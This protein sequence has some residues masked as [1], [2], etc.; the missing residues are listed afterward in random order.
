MKTKRRQPISSA[1]IFKLMIFLAYLVSALFFVKDILGGDI[2]GACIIGAVLGVFT[3]AL[4]VMRLLKVKPDI[5]RL[6]VA[7]S[8]IVIVFIVSLTTGSYY[9]DD[10]SLYLAVIALNGL[11]F[12]KKYSYVQMAM[13]DIFLV[14]Q[15]VVYPHKA[16]P[17]GQFIMCMATFNLAAI[18]ICLL[19]SRGSAFIENN[20][21]R[22]AAAEETLKELET[23]GLELE[24]NFAASAG[25]MDS[26][27]A[28]NHT[29]RESADTLQRNSSGISDGA[30]SVSVSCDNVRSRMQ[31]TTENVHALDRGVKRFESVLNENRSNMA[32]MNSQMS[33]VRN[34]I[35]ETDRVFHLL[36]EQMRKI[37]SVTGEIN[38][39]ASNTGLLAVNASIEAARAGE[40]GKGFAVVASN[41]RALAVDSTR[42]SNEVAEVVAS[43]QKQIDSTTQQLEDSVTAISASMQ[44]LRSL[45]SGFDQL[46]HEFDALYDNIEAQTNGI[47]TV[48]GIFDDLKSRVEDMSLSSDEN[49]ASVD[50]ITETMR[51]YR[52]NIAAVVEDNRRIRELSEQMLDL[53]QT[54]EEEL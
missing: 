2:S 6:V 54:S 21:Y 32:E 33:T 51:V 40:A 44:T 1:K 9:S 25:R 50:V 12:K 20:M 29:M 42:S 11:Y 16:D 17:L 49:K 46:T 14:I 24:Q 7:S 35:Q 34:A 18:T 39:I 5:Q 22:A 36:D 48:N 13:A 43:M 53:A 30:S 47:D 38:Q 45:Q 23:I 10:Y 37:S 26:L 4:V 19:V 41:V 28:A 52:D 15:F 27:Q 31:E 3:L 8:L